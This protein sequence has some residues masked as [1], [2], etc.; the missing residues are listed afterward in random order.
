MVQSVVGKTLS[1][2]CCPLAMSMLCQ[3]QGLAMV[4]AETCRTLPA[5]AWS[6]MCFVLHSDYILN[7]LLYEIYPAMSYHRCC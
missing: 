4:I 5:R 7:Q 2:H 6:Q 1:K 3:I